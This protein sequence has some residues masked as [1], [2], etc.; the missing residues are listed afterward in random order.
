MI[1]G[2]C[3]KSP[4]TLD[5][6]DALWIESI[7]YSNLDDSATGILEGS[8]SFTSV[9]CVLIEMLFS[10]SGSTAATLT[11]TLVATCR[12]DTAF[13]DLHESIN[14]VCFSEK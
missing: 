11:L 6:F 7:L 10:N 1:S 2:I 9:S 13:F 3:F 5:L 12:F 4:S 8:F 14:L